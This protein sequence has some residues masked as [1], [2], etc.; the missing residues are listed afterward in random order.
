M[1]WPSPAFVC[2]LAA[3][4]ESLPRAADVALDPAVLGFT[5]LVSLVTGAVFGLAPLLHLSPDTL[6]T[7][8]KEGGARAQRSGARHRVRR[9]LVMAEVALAVVLVVGAGLML[10][11]VVNLMQVDS[12]FDR[13]QLTTF[14]LDLPTPIRR[15]PGRGAL[16]RGPAARLEQVPGVRR[17]RDVG[18]AAE[19]AAQRERHRHRG[20]R[21]AVR[22]GP[23]ENVDYY[24]FATIGTSR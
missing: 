21:E 22:E 2:S 7:S 15:R 10:R 6:V 3:Y 19:S 12:G 9:A 1:C 20:L 17:R 5:L 23:I 14:A 13:A 24:Q 16:L 8:L 11:T 4:P 18:A